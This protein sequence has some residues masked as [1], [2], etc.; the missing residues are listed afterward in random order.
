MYTFQDQPPLAEKLLDQFRSTKFGIREYS[1][2]MYGPPPCDP[3]P[4]WFAKI[5]SMALCRLKTLFLKREPRVE[6]KDVQYSWRV[7][8]WRADCLR[9]SQPVT[10]R[11]IIDGFGLYTVCEEVVATPET[12]LEVYR[13]NMEVPIFAS[14]G[15]STRTGFQQQRNF[16]REVDSPK[17]GR[18]EHLLSGG[19]IKCARS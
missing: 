9:V 19:D 15:P 8:I 14:P 13:R 18:D 16:T 7:L 6:C 12:R 3:A 10:Y 5:M 2:Q 1:F 11:Y 4:R 17:S